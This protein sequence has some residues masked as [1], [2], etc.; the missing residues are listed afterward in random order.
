MA[1][2]IDLGKRARERFPE[3]YGS[4]SD[5]DAGVR[6]KAAYPGAYDDFVDTVTV[7]THVRGRPIK[8]A[9]D[10]EPQST[11]NPV[12]G[13][14]RSIGGAVGGMRAGVPGATVGGSVG[15]VL[16]Q[17]INAPW[18]Q[19]IPD[20]TI[21]TL[22]STFGDVASSPSP[23]EA[24]KQVGLAGLEQGAYEA[25]GRVVMGGVKLGGNAAASAALRFTPET[26]QTMIR[27]GI[28]ATRGGFRKLTA[29]IVNVGDQTTGLVRRAARRGGMKF[30]T[31]TQNAVD[32]VSDIVEKKLKTQGIYGESLQELNDIRNRFVRD[33]GSHMSLERAH[34]VKKTSGQAVDPVFKK[35]AKGEMVAISKSAVEDLWD[36]EMSGYLNQRIGS[37]V[38]GYHELNTLESSLIAL[39]QAMKPFHNVAARAAFSP[40]GRM[41]AGAAAGTLLPGDDR[42]NAMRGAAAGLLSTPQM[43][44]ILAMV[45]RN[46]ALLA[47]FGQAPRAVGAAAHE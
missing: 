26:A 4:L 34:Q 23:D 43:L 47:L 7:K 39:K 5:Y 37:V 30:M 1:T 21:R 36:K 3:E 8:K 9:A 38:S 12:V 31:P 27:E 18:A 46:P 44:S 20:H 29:R 10:G 6:V 33:N 28:T 14:L 19:A 40:A 41:S 25:G 45:S 42:T 22:A 35:N 32:T 24:L 11:E 15:E 2:V 17:T 16:R 13:N